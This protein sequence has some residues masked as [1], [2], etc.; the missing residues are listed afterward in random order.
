M[1]F[2]ITSQLRKIKEIKSCLL[3]KINKV[4]RPL[5]NLTEKKRRQNII[6]IINVQGS[7]LQIF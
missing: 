5:I 6:N 4:D 1:K 3:E 7:T 2:K